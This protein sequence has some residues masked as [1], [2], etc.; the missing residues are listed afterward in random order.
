MDRNI[1]IEKLNIIRSYYPDTPYITE[2]D[3]EETIL[4]KYE[5]CLSRM[6]EKE[7]NDLITVVTVIINTIVDKYL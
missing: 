2:N 5:S 7:Y 4:F 6:R 3:T 1:Y